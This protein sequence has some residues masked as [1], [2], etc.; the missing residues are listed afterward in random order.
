MKKLNRAIAYLSLGSNVG[1]RAQ[2]LSDAIHLLQTEN[3]HPVEASSIY[4]TSAWGLRDQH[5]FL[6]QVLKVETSLKAEE[7][8]QVILDTELK[9]GRKRTIK[10]GPRVIDIDI[11]FYNS[12]IIN[13]KGLTLPHPHL[14]KRNFVLYPLAEIAPGLLHPVL[15][16]TSIE[17]LQMSEDELKV[18]IFI[19]P[20]TTTEK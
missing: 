4:E 9:M 12:M 6:N 10:Y 7:L 2:N 14:H 18:N 1:N 19:P 17:L 13:K 15:H 5:D 8:L 3:I 16:K 11:L 20:A